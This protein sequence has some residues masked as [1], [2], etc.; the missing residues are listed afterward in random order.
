MNTRNF[1]FLIAL[2]LLLPALLRGE[3]PNPIFLWPKDAPG[4]EGKTGA[5]V[6]DKF[7][8]G[9]RKVSGI[10]RPSITPYLPAKDK[11]TGTAII[12]APGGAHRF[13][14]ID[15]EGYN[16]GK[17]L[18]DRGIAA[19]VLKYRLA[20]ETN[21]TYEIKTHALAD[22]QRAIRMV[23]SRAHEWNINPEHIGIMGFSAGGELAAL[24]G[25]QFDE[26][27]KDSTNPIDQQSARPNFQA[28]IYPGR[29]GDIQPTTNSVPVFLA[30]AY[31]DRPDIS[32]GLAEVYLRFKKVKVPAE[33]HIYSNG[34]HGFGLRESNKSPVG[35]WAARFEEWVNE[36]VK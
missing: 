2:C 28:L 30:C 34:G 31:N 15:H 11:A 23:R 4:S 16:V 8:N 13:L 10:H 32:E 14:A 36:T 26:G 19:F 1:A 7:S 17:F 20:K 22:T 25:T 35:N 27:R 9:E 6:V 21:S 3:E 29:A 24:A 5:E 12:I 18:S 33:L